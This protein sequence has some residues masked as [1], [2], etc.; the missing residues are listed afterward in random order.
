MKLLIKLLPA[1]GPLP[2]GTIFHGSQLHM[3][4][5]LFKLFC[6]RDY[7]ARFLS[8]YGSVPGDDERNF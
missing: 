7:K 1:P 6:Y 5:F 2:Y 3:D 8:R 4:R